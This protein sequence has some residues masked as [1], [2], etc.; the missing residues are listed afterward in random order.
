MNEENKQTNTK[1]D[2][3]SWDEHFKAGMDGLRSELRDTIDSR[4][5]L[6]SVRMHG[7][8]AMKEALLAW[9]SLLDGMINKMDESEKASAQRATKI[10]I[11]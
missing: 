5:T 1:T 2:P 9:R 10:N 11:E 8:A 3:L 4:E 7:R 6:N